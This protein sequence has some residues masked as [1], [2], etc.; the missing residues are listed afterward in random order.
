MYPS[1]IP[2]LLGCRFLDLNGPALSEHRMLLNTEINQLQIFDIMGVKSRPQHPPP[3]LAL[4]AY[5]EPFPRGG[6][7][8]WPLEAWGVPAFVPLGLLGVGD[9]RVE[10]ALYAIQHAHLLLALEL[11]RLCRVSTAET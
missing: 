6:D 11:D 9:A 10:L 4:P 5:H 7:A 1:H 3:Y 8:L 2:E